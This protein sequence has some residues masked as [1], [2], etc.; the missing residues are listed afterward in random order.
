MPHF[1]LIALIKTVGY[2]GVAGMVFAESGLL[3]G[4]FLPGD[5]L[6]FTAG[7]LASQGFL[8]IW[9]LAPLSFLAAVLGDA[10]GYGF[11]RRFGRSLFQRPG[12]TFFKPENLERAEAFFERHGGKALVFARFLPIVRTFTPIVA[13]A[14]EMRYSRFALFNI[15][16]GF[17]WAVGVSVGGYFLGSAIPNV[18]RYLLP[19]IMLILVAS[20]APTAIHIWRENGNE[21]NLAVR[22]RLRRST[23]R[24]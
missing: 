17:L 11:G 21:I 10:V 12:S 5:S 15:T 14:A 7:F 22:K 9:I 13:G 8:S 2:L 4:F 6:L 20:V 19:I 3:I 1:D 18:D 24:R 23:M 16:G